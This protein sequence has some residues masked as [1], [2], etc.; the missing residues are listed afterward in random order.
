MNDN[1]R[2]EVLSEVDEIR[3]HLN[4]QE[5]EPIDA[6]SPLADPSQAL[7]ELGSISCDQSQMATH[8][9]IKAAQELSASMNSSRLTNRR[10][11]V[12]R[13]QRNFY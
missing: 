9:A 13:Q 3:H 2:H 4:S 5:F 1:A 12:V 8:P 7:S 10:D 11:P 6:P